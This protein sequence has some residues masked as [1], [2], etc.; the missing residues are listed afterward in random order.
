M[1]FHRDILKIENIKLTTQELQ[2]FINKQ[3]INEFGKKGAVVG[4]SGG[5]DSAVL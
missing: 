3:I 4:L 2:D 5:I 1:D